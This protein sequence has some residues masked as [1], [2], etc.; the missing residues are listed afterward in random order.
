MQFH[1]SRLSER[2]WALPPRFEGHAVGYRVCEHVGRATGAVHSHVATCELQPGGSID[3]HVQS[4][5]QTVLVLDGILALTT[6]GK[7][8]LLHQN[9]CAFIP[10]GTTHAW[11]N[12]GDDTC[13]WVESRTPLPRAAQQPPD[14]FFVEPLPPVVRAATSDPR[15]RHVV[16]FHPSSMAAV[17]DGDGGLRNATDALLL[18]GG[19]SMR[20]LIDARQ[21]AALS[22]IFAIRFP[23]GA[24]VGAHDHP[25]EEVYYML[26]GEVCFTVDGRDHTLRAGDVA[27]TAVG[28]VHV[29]EN[30][31]SQPAVWLETQTP[32]PPLMNGARF[33]KAWAGL[34]S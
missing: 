4:A 5:E 16:T 3:S 34:S 32:L 27:F 1:T 9:Q 11:R 24:A 28:C 33:T 13:R 10:V 19:V 26:E 29:V 21:G 12:A 8:F 23:S 6:D 22:N 20:M 30:R 2:T 15:N 25:H 18:F 31:S 17:S 14:T 7:E